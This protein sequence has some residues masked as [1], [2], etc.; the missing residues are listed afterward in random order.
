VYALPI[1][2]PTASPV[3]PTIYDVAERANVS[4]ATV[5]RVFN[6]Q[7]RVANATRERVLKVADALGYSP[8][9]SA[10]NLALQKT[11]LLAAVVPFETDFFY[12]QV[13][14]GMQDALFDSEFDLTIYLAPEK[15]ETKG[16]LERALQPGRA[17][18]VVLLSAELSDAQAEMV[19]ASGQPL[20]LVDTHHSF[21]D[22]ISVDNDEGAY[23]A[24][25]RLLA[26]GYQRIAHI[27]VA[28][29]APAP[30]RNRRFGYEQALRQGGQPVDP[31]LVVYST[32]YPFGFM[33][34]AGY[35]AMQ[36]LL[37]LPEPP[38]AVFACSDVQALGALQALRDHG[39]RAPDDVAIVGFDDIHTSRHVGLSTLRQPMRE[40][41]KLAVQ[42]LLQRIAQPARTPSKT[43]FAPEYIA[44][45]TCGTA[46]SSEATAA[47]IAL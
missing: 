11:S 30:A 32:S 16:Q 18:G 39:L 17:D 9:I 12:A 6:N 8:H 47:A 20:V 43:V 35:E 5:S 27:T 24:V 28:P 44:R 41:G 21:F 26:H 37:A 13:M 22:S 7:T 42:K 4:T 45:S 15:Q 10:Q 31:E 19:Q 23:D 2:C 3:P 40:M 36:Q 46:A 29:E 34:E 1:N 38:D 25:Q 14:R 33:E